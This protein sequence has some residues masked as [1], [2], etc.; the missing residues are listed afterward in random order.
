MKKTISAILAALMVICTLCLTAC[1]DKEK[2]DNIDEPA[3]VAEGSEETQANEETEKTTEAKPLEATEEDFE[4]L[5][6][7]MLD[8]GIEYDRTSRTAVADAY[9]IAIGHMGIYRH[10]FEEEEGYYG[11]EA[12]PKGYFLTEYGDGNYEYS[13]IPEENAD[14]IVENIMGIEPDHELDEL[15]PYEGATGHYMYYHEGNYYV[16]GFVGGSFI[17]D[18]KVV[19]YDVYGDGIYSLDIEVY[20]SDMGEQYLSH[21]AEVTAELKEIDGKN[22]WV[23]HEIELDYPDYY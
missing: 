10:F 15:Y 9:N 4:Y 20:E 1:S 11:P 7:L 13:V 5:C 14:W 21:E 19:D 23:F 3:T 16:S 6:K 8:I 18:T 22:E 12:D 2:P 17:C